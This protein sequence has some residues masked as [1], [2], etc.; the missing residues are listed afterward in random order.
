[1]YKT[2]S[3]IA[4]T[5]LEKLSAKEDDTSLP[6]AAAR[7]G[8]LGFSLGALLG[9][10]R[11]KSEASAVGEKALKDF[12]GSQ[13]DKLYKGPG[14]NPKRMSAADRA[15]NARMLKRFFQGA[16]GGTALGVGTAV[17]GTALYNHLKNREEG[18]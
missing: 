12:I 6:Q 5:V 2:A 13:E 16:G 18:V 3:E 7:G 8:S 1:M 14:L 15:I 10:N 11:G 4:D 9:A 17:G